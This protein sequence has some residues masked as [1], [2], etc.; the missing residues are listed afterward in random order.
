MLGVVY[1]KVKARHP[2]VTVL[3]G[4]LMLNEDLLEF[5]GDVLASGA[6]DYYDGLSFHGYVYYPLNE[7]QSIDQKVALLRD[8]GETA[9]LWLT[10]TS[11]LCLEWYIECGAEFER[12]QADYYKH[13]T[14]N[15]STIGVE[16]FIWFTLANNK[17]RNS[18]L[19]EKDV[20][21]AAWYEYIKASSILRRGQKGL[22]SE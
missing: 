3:A 12:A 20:P 21:R 17:W 15:G 8:L 4:S 19:V 9:P 14:R 18:D 22:S 11:M 16:R 6:G 10:E 7:Y 13:L 1:P 5:W 2:E